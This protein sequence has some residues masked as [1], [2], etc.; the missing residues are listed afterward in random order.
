M[1]TSLFFKKFI[2][3][4]RKAFL[5]LI[6]LGG[7]SSGNFIKIIHDGDEAFHNIIQAIKDAKKN[8]MIETYILA[9]D[10]LGELLQKELIKAQLRGVS[11]TILYDHIGSSGIS[12]RFIA[13]FIEANIKILDFNPIWPWRNR[14][15]L[16]FRDHRKIMIIDDMLAFCGGINIS[17]DYAGPIYGNDRFR[18]SVALVKGPAVKHLIDISKESLAESEF[19]ECPQALL[20]ALPSSYNLR[21]YIRFL[22]QRLWPS[23]NHSLLKTDNQEALI[24]VLRSNT[25]RNL[26]HIQ[27]SIEEAVNRSI[28]YCYFTTPYFLPHEPLRL[29]MINAK[30]R[31]VDVRILTA[32][33][34][35]V[36]LMRYASHHIY[37]NFLSHGVRIYEMTAKTL[38]AKLC[39]IDGIYASIGS[40]NLDHWSARRNLEVTL[41]I[42]DKD[43]TDNLKH[44]FNKD[45]SLSEEINY[46][47]FR[48]RHIIKRIFCYLAYQIMRL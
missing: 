42:I 45:L 32:G 1:K 6:P 19:N 40:F 13:N 10:S 34:S 41:S 5:H 44:Q 14:G 26:L 33:I 12:S 37:D 16:L 39:S 38:H 29:A 48:N 43:I 9:D 18:D 4:W 8:I 22:G 11:I 36:P 15:P 46:Q 23:R 25:R 3:S 27:K 30:K 35:D 21:D 24:Q 28:S 17:A 20:L 7:V 31:G 47:C 2:I